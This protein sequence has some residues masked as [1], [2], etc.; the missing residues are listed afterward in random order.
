MKNSIALELYNN[1]FY[2]MTDDAFEDLRYLAEFLSTDYRNYDQ[3]IFNK[4]LNFYNSSFVYHDLAHKI[5]YIGFSEWEVRTEIPVPCDYMFPDYVSEANSCKISLNNYLEF[6]KDWMRL[7]RM[8]HPFAMIYRDD[9]NWVHCEGF[10]SRNE[11]RLFTQ[12]NSS[13]VAD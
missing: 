8:L 7:I 9:N 2:V 1:H 12:N 5:L 13:E 10:E 11:M 6:R 3:N 4:S